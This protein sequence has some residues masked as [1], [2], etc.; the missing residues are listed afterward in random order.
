MNKRQRKKRDYRQF[1]KEYRTYKESLN[2]LPVWYWK[3][4]LHDAH[5][6]DVMELENG[7]D[8]KRGKYYRNCLVLSLDSSGALFDFNVKK[9]IFYNYEVRMADASV[10]SLSKTWWMTDQIERLSNGNCLLNF[11]VDPENHERWCF[12]IEFEYADVERR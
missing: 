6:L 7:I 10:S 9:I 2:K 3:R 4:G 1:E 11:E 5:I 12:S 8:T